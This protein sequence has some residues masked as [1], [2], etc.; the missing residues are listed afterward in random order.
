M[1]AFFTWLEA[2][3]VAIVVKDSLLLTAG[4][5]AVHVLGMTLITGGAVV[6]NMRLLG[7]LLAS[8]DLVTITR[9]AARGIAVGLLLSVTSGLLLF[10]ARATAAGVNPAFRTK[11]VILVTASLF[12]FTVHGWACR[13]IVNRSAL[14]LVGVAGLCLW[15]GVAGAGAYYILVGE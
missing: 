2:T 12:Q 11:M 4:L 7:A 13:H 1:L 8:D 14:R 3:S 5:S 15:I 6:S 9:A 10:M